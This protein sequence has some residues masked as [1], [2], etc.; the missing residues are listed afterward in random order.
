MF[1]S[2][3]IPATEPPSREALL[4]QVRR[5][6]EM[7]FIAHVLQRHL[8]ALCRC[9]VSW[10]LLLPGDFGNPGDHDNLSGD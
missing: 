8:E 10:P 7:E 4:R 1:P 2:R 5:T 3:M 9:R 6:A